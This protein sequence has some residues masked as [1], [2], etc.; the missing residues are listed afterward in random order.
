VEALPARAAKAA[1]PLRH[2]VAFVLARRDPA[3]VWLRRRPPTGLLGG[4]LEVPSTPWEFSPPDKRKINQFAPG[5]VDW[6]P[7]P[8][9]V[10]HVFTHFELHLEVRLAVVDGGALTSLPGDGAWVA[11]ERLAGAGLPTVMK[12]ILDHAGFAR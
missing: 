8:G 5:A 7:L 4:M 10:R 12:K 2:G 3:A 6:P 9:T 1:R 11:T